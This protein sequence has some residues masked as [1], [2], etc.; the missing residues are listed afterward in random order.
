MSDSS[1]LIRKN[2]NNLQKIV[3]IDNGKEHPIMMVMKAWAAKWWCK[4]F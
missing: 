3:I 4:I 2:Q 1:R